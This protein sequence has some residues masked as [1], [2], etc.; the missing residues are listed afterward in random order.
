MHQTKMPYLCVLTVFAKQTLSAVAK[1]NRHW[2]C[3]LGYGKLIDYIYICHA[4]RASNAVHLITVIK[5]CTHDTHV[6][7]S[8][9]A[10]LL[11][12]EKADNKTK[13]ASWRCPLQC[14]MKTHTSV[15]HESK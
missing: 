2:G 8:A 3:A 1:F 4:I 15:V 5:P 6:I 14:G 10:C 9:L 12:Q 13:F 11:V 7:F